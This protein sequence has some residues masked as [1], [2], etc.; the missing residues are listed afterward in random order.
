M[1]FVALKK[2]GAKVWNFLNS[3]IPPFA[4]QIYAKA[5]ASPC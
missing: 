4:M 3:N 5:P 1:K 2:G